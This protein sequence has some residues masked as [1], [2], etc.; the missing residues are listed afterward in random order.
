MMRLS[1]KAAA[2]AAFCLLSLLSTRCVEPGSALYPSTA[3]EGDRDR[4]SPALPDTLSPDDTA[5]PAGLD[6]AADRR[7][8]HLVGRVVDRE[9]APIPGAI[10]SLARYFLR[11]TTD[12]QGN[13]E[14]LLHEGRY[15]P[16]RKPALGA[17]PGDS[18][19]VFRDGVLV[20]VLPLDAYQDTLPDIRVVER[21]LGVR[22]GPGPRD[23]ARVEAMLWKASD[24]VRRRAELAPEGGAA[25]GTRIHFVDSRPEDGYRIYASAY[26]DDGA[27]LGRTDTA[28]FRGDAGDI[29]LPFLDP[30]GA[31]PVARASVS[32]GIVGA[33]EHIVL[34][35]SARDPFGGTIDKWE[36]DVG[37]T[38]SFRHTLDSVLV[39]EAPHHPVEDLRCVL[40]ATDPDGHT[41]LDTVTVKVIR[42]D[43]SAHGFRV[44]WGDMHGHS[45]FST[46]YR[47]HGHSKDGDQ[48]CPGSEGCQSG[49]DGYFANALAE[50]LDFAALTDHA[51]DLTASEW[52]ATRE[53][54]RAHFRPGVF[55][56]LLGYEYCDS[57]GTLE[58]CYN[59]IFPDDDGTVYA[60]RSL[61]KVDSDDVAIYL[62][63]EHE[64]WPRLRDAHP[65][66]FALVAHPPPGT[67]WEYPP[68]KRQFVLGA[69][70]ASTGGG[71][72]PWES[73][74]CK[75]PLLDGLRQGLALQVFGGGNDHEGRPGRAALT[76]ALVRDHSREALIEAF[77]ARRTYATRGSRVALSFEV[78]GMIMG[79]EI[80]LEAT[81]PDDRRPVRLA[82]EA[83][84]RGA[85][86]RSLSFH[87]IGGGE[88][89]PI[90]VSTRL[91]HAVEA[92]AIDTVGP[93]ETA[94]YWAEVLLEGQSDRYEA[95]AWTSP[96]IVRR[97]EAAVVAAPAQ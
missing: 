60:G 59:V 58:S 21:R 55:V 79:S 74:I 45:A 95:E 2:L 46:D 25:F 38:G 14:L 19:R 40:R 47:H 64:L 27:L 31:F 82:A 51:E 29:E 61:G 62:Q 8:V 63:G 7:K 89:R 77:H 36:W 83:V 10:A 35:G 53:A 34:M 43:P 90:H 75:S 91:D 23:V 9:G 33:G 30:T 54:V 50:G 12:N 49:A 48:E 78:D 42:A 16:P 37:S 76:A 18:L 20:A 6:T 24:T 17:E 15:T 69:E 87:R 13:Y 88:R 5:R 65:G 67:R 22:V 71:P 94:V 70:I 3:S 73:R 44:L 56:P 41:G 96:V 1:R 68:L 39:V 4:N 93:G 84:S 28:E 32:P 66:A 86:I 52:E 80:I 92:A 85:R 11:D 97:P 26:G 72:D 57:V 81:G